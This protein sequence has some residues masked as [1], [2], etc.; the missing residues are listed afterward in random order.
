MSHLFNFLKQSPRISHIDVLSKYRQNESLIQKTRREYRNNGICIDLVSVS[1]ELRGWL[2]TSWQSGKWDNQEA[3]WG[4]RGQGEP[5][6]P[7]GKCHRWLGEKSGFTSAPALGRLQHHRDFCSESPAQCIVHVCAQ[8]SQG[9]LESKA[10]VSSPQA[11]TY[12]ILKDSTQ[13]KSRGAQRD[14]RGKAGS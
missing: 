3:E 11:L 13:P 10:F 8:V 2:T 6:Q 1:V 4:A 5:R 9:T 14:W 7:R 12:R